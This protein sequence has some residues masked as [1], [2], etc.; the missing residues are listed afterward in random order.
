MTDRFVRFT[1]KATAVFLCMLLVM[2]IVAFISIFWWMVA[3]FGPLVALGGLVFGV[4]FGL[5]VFF[6]M[7]VAFVDALAPL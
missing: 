4:G 6:Q 5:W 7:L 3:Q 2:C 1:L